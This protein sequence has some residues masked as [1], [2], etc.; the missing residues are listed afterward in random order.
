MWLHA[1]SCIY[2]FVPRNIDRRSA[3]LFSVVISAAAAAE[4]IS[5][6]PTLQQ[7]A[8]WSGLGQGLL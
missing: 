4:F 3:T 6:A 2:V 1:F 7:N 5:F 8:C